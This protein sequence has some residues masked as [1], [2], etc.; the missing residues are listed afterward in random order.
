MR[1]SPE[2][3][4]ATLLAR[5]TLLAQIIQQSQ[6][7]P[8]E[9]D[10]A[11]TT[12]LYPTT[13]RTALGM[14]TMGSIRAMALMI[15]EMALMIREMV[16]MIPVTVLMIPVTVPMILVTVPMMVTMVMTVMMTVMTAQTRVTLYGNFI[17][18][19]SVYSH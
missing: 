9:T 18:I 15:L 8:L 12:L 13:D 4:L 11:R 2:V 17:T 6:T 1:I 16:L 19:T 14:A 10:L 7:P 3:I 5:V